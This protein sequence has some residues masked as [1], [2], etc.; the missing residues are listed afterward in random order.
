MYCVLSPK[1]RCIQVK[2]ISTVDDLFRDFFINYKTMINHTT[3][4]NY[5]L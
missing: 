1:G 4:I 5:Y 3:T 2:D